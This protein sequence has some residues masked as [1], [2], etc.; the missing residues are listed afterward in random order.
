[1]PPAIKR[2]DGSIF[3]AAEIDGTVT[4]LMNP[5]ESHRRRHRESLIDG[6]IVY[7]KTYGFR[8][9]KKSRP[10]TRIR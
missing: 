1:M 4:R 8:D 5:C 6:K 10:L 3:T 7:L 9:L 2:L